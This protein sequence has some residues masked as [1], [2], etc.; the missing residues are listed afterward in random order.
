MQLIASN[1]TS[2]AQ[3]RT[4]LGR[5]P[6]EPNAARVKV[7]VGSPERTP[8]IDA[9]PTSAYKL[10][11][12]TTASSAS[13]TSRP[14]SNA[15]TPTETKNRLA[16]VPTQK[17]AVSRSVMRRSASGMWS[18]PCRSTPK[19]GLPLSGCVLR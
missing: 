8:P 1:A 16:L 3:V 4:P 13:Q 10:V 17:N 7:S 14:S 15:I 11:P 19:T 12:S 5:L 9:T 6:R 2:A 18:N